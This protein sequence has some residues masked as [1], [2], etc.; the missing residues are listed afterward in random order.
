[1]NS[2]T[3]SAATYQPGVLKAM[4]KTATVADATNVWTGQFERPKVNNSG[5]SASSAAGRSERSTPGGQVRGRH[6]SAVEHLGRNNGARRPGWSAGSECNRAWGCVAGGCA[7]RR[8]AVVAEGLTA[9]S[10]IQAGR[11]A[12]GNPTGGA[13]A[14]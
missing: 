9:R 13:V 1:M 11:T 10:S 7:D 2:P 3:R 4:Q 6:G 8:P 14:V 12:Q 5:R